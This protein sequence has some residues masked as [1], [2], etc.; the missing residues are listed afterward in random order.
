ME[1]CSLA[2]KFDGGISVP[3]NLGFVTDI[4]PD[5]QAVTM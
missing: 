5:G 2:S 1:Q 4:S 3:S